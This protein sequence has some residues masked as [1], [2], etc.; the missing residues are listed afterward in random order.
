MTKKVRPFRKSVG[1]SWDVFRLT[2]AYRFL[3]VNDFLWCSVEPRKFA[4]F[5]KAV[6]CLGQSPEEVEGD[7]G[8]YFLREDFDIVP[9]KKEKNL[10]DS[11]R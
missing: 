6:Y 4:E 1:K 11:K 9:E 5:D 3:I 7:L 2:E 8:D 10:N